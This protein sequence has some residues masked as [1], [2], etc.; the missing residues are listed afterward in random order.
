MVT[1]LSIDSIEEMVKHSIDI[2]E[3]EREWEPNDGVIGEGES[4]NTEV[5]EFEKTEMIINYDLA[6]EWYGADI[7]L[8]RSP[9]MAV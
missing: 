3:N 9:E 2:I 4:V 1:K 5:I 7:E 8:R 6:C